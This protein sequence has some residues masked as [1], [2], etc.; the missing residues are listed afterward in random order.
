MRSGKRARPFSQWWR[1]LPERGPSMKRVLL[2]LLVIGGVFYPAFVFFAGNGAKLP[3]GELR[4]AAQSASAEHAAP[5]DIA[6][7][8]SRQNLWQNDA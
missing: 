1:E 6:A 5:P 4:L 3:D 2:S 8:G 7:A